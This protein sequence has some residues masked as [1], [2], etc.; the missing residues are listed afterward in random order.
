MIE[1]TES[2]LSAVRTAMARAAT[3]AEGLR[4]MVQSGGCAGLKYVMGLERER[5][6]G[7]VVVDQDGVK[8]Y[9]DPTSQ[10]LAAGMVVD[11][12][13]GL[14]SSGFVFDN[15]NAKSRCSCGKFFC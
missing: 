8:L 1:L 3:P 4:I 11:F 2:A 6:D 13:T 15:P 14:D 12:V 10:N 5:R 9:I 7:D